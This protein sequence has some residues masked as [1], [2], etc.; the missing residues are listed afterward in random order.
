[1]SI[2]IDPFLKLKSIFISTK[3]FQQEITNC[4]AK[5]PEERKKFLT[6]IYTGSELYVEDRVIKIQFLFFA[7]YFIDEVLQIIKDIRFDIYNEIKI[8][9]ENIFKCEYIETEVKRLS[10]LYSDL[11]SLQKNYPIIDDDKVME[12]MKNWL[13]P[14]REIKTSDSP[15]DIMFIKTLNA[16][17]NEAYIY[18]PA[19]SEK[20]ISKLK[21]ASNKEIYAL[22]L[23]KIEL[24][25]WT[26]INETIEVNK[27][28][29]E[30][31]FI[32][33]PFPPFLTEKNNNNNQ[34]ETQLSGTCNN[35]LTKNQ[36]LQTTVFNNA[37]P[38]LLPKE[39][40]PDVE[41]NLTSNI[42]QLSMNKKEPHPLNPY[43]EFMDPENPPKE[44]TFNEFL[45]NRKDFYKPYIDN[46]NKPFPNIEAEKLVDV[47]VK[48]NPN[49]FEILQRSIT[50]FEGIDEPTD[51]FLFAKKTLLLE[52]AK[53]EAE[54]AILKAVN[55]NET[56]K[57]II[58]LLNEGIRTYE[59]AILLP[60]R[61]KSQLD[62]LKYH[63]Q[64]LKNLR[65]YLLEKTDSTIPQQSVCL[66]EIKNSENKFWKGMPMDKVIN[67]F[68]KEFKD[69]ENKFNKVPLI[70]VYKY[71][72]QLAEEPEKPFLTS[73][74]VFDFIDKSFCCN[75][76]IDKLEFTNTNKKQ[77]LIWKLFHNFYEDCTNSTLYDTTKHTKE[78][79]V[80]LITDNFTNWDYR[81]VY[82]N[83]ANANSR[84]WKRL[85]DY[86]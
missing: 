64:G 22:V 48:E 41:G 65:D 56:V 40:K 74:E 24:E 20:L 68:E 15:N 14:Q 55:K 28:I 53:T 7:F 60:G 67:H 44:K 82:D 70:Q 50:L 73:A 33:T 45:A 47:F 1:M 86:K 57:Y 52:E 54:K 63:L 34:S 31:K 81:A 75:T 79:Y 37:A 6:D 10:R 9:K 25:I 8:R 16:L 77:G 62:L 4:G 32:I 83:F 58:N 43:R 49:W 13:P 59:M 42:S 39:I 78:K 17:K 12:E 23:W 38:T 5:L 27:D 3:N 29:L 69:K 76:E 26:L 66:D 18:S 11:S 36:Q 71:F 61:K 80:K 84:H 35:C 19:N 21:N 2:N 72:M 85:K 51:P 46:Q 30:K